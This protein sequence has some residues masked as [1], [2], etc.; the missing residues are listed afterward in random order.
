MDLNVAYHNAFIFKNLNIHEKLIVDN[1]TNKVLLDE[2]YG[3]S[4]RR[5]YTDDN[6][7]DLLTAII[8]TF[9]IL[10]KNN[11]DYYELKRIIKNLIITCAHTY[12]EFDE[13]H[14]ELLNIHKQIEINYYKENEEDSLGCFDNMIFYL[15]DLYD[16]LIRF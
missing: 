13:L 14:S 3:Q 4:V 15:V 1:T 16:E 5:W 8:S 9:K 10:L 2:R 11:Y 6:R 12:Y 7:N